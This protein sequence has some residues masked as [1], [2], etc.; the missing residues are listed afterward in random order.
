MITQQRTVYTSVPLTN[1]SL[2]YKN[3]DYICEAIAPIMTVMKDSGKI[4]SYGMENLRIV[5]TYRSVGGKP[6]IVET[7]VSSSDHYSLDDH[8]LGEFIPEEVIENQEAPINA[9]IDV[10]EALTDRMLVDKEKALADVLTNTSVITQN[11]T[12]SGVDQWN[13]YVNS[14]PIEDIKTAVIAVRAGSGKKPNTLIISWDALQTLLNHP[15][16]K[17]FFPGA[18]MISQDMVMTNMVRLFGLKK[19]LVGEA[20]Y[21]NSNLGG[22]DT[23]T[24]IWSKVAI[25]AYIEESPRLKSR[26]LAM[27][28]T[29]K[30]PRRVDLLPQGQGGLETVQRKSDYVQISDKYDQVIVDAKCAY[31]IKAAIA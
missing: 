22:T 5:N 10:V 2:A 18:P 21:N 25:V 24:D 4:Y 23:L 3:E 8:T 11:V 26:T 31:L 1:I 16:I 27:T 7:T 19:L 14:D 20:Q 29:K 13:D 6:N 17:A 12:L 28:Y 9:R 15:D 30:A